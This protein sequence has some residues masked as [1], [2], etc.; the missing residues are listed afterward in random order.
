MDDG[1]SG[2]EDDDRDGRPRRLSEEQLDEI[3]LALR[4]PPENFGLNSNL[5]DGRTLASYITKFFD[6]DLGTR[7]CQRLFRE[8]GFRYR[9]PRPMIAGLSDEVKDDF[10][11]N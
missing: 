8:L 2:L 5:W 7:Q 1:L 9:K 4:L 6:I 11:K 10:K 3:S